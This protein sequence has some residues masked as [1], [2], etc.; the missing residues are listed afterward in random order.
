MLQTPRTCPSLSE[1]AITLPGERIVATLAAC[2]ITVWT[3]VALI[4]AC[5]RKE[6][7][8]ETARKLEANRSLIIRILS[9]RS[10][11]TR[12]IA[13]YNLQG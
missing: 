6:Q 10:W 12:K 1:T 2:A 11:V 9:I 4:A 3:S 13:V 5:T 7:R 8:K